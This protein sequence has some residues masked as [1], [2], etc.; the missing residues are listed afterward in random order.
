MSIAVKC[1][2]CQKYFS[3]IEED[4]CSTFGA[5]KY[6]RIENFKNHTVGGL[7]YREL[8]EVDLYKDCTIDFWK[9]MNRPPIEGTEQKEG[10]YY[11]K[12][13]VPEMRNGD[14]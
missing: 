6:Y 10:D 8:S 11:E 1:D 7:M 3:A 5:P 12:N 2:R 14:V 13:S 9:F 4:L